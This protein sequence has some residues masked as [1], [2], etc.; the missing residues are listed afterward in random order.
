MANRTLRRQYRQE[1]VD[2]FDKKLR[3]FR[4]SLAHKERR[5]LREIIAAAMS[6]E[7]DD[8]TGGYAMMDDEALLQALSSYLK[9][10]VSPDA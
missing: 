1:D 4:E 3:G 7:D 2:E 10:R 9:R 5:M 6:E 8:D